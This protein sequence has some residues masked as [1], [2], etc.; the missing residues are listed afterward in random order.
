MG[1]LALGEVAQ[2]MDGCDVIRRIGELKPAQRRTGQALHRPILALWAIGQ[3][4]QGKPRQQRWSEV[5]E[6]VPLLGLAA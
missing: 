2:T 4:A 5:R 3:A 6:V 1:L